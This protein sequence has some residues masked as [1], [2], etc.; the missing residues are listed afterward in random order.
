[1]SFDMKG[2]RRESELYDVRGKRGENLRPQ[3]VS[4]PPD[5][6]EARHEM[7]LREGNHRIKNSLQI[8]SSLMSLQ[9]NREENPHARDALRSAAMRVQSVARMHDALQASDGED[10][11]D[12]G[13]ALETMC[14]SLQAMGGDALGVAVLVETQPCQAPVAIARSIGLA[15]NELVVNALR[16]AFPDGRAGTILVKLTCHGGQLRLLVADD[17]IGLPPDHLEGRGYGMKLVRMMVKQ[18]SGVLYVDSGAGTRITIVLPE[19]QA[20]V[21]AQAEPAQATPAGRAGPVRRSPWPFRARTE[22]GK[23]NGGS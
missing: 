6:I 8:V 9:A 2:V 17:G 11:V 5:D 4:E 23:P 21:A 10:S 14:G 19:Q 20:A 18:I 13:A 15:L 7:L 12:L 1:M 3:H 22:T 16:H